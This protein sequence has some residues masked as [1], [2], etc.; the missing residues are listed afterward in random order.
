MLFKLA[1]KNAKKSFKDYLI[2]FLT[3]TISISVF[4]MVNSIYDQ[5]ILLNLQETSKKYMKDMSEGI[6]Y[7]SIFLAVVI[8]FLVVSTNSF[9]IKRRKKELGIYMVLGMEKNKISL[10]LILEILFIAIF[11]LTLGILVGTILSQFMSFLI[12]NMFIVDMTK[13]TFVFSIGSTM[14]TIS[15]FSV[16]F[17]VIM[18]FNM[19][20]ISKVK[21]IDLL[22]ANK[23][24]SKFKIRSNK[25][26]FILFFISIISLI[27]SYYL[28]L[29]SSEVNP[30]DI[31]SIQI[32]TMD[33][34]Y[35]IL[36]MVGTFL[37]FTSFIS[38]AIN[39]LK[40]N[41]RFYYNKIN[42][43]TVRQINSN[44]IN[45]FASLSVICFILFFIIITGSIGFSMK[46]HFS[47]TIEKMPYN[48]SMYSTLHDNDS[49]KEEKNI[50]I[51]TGTK[52]YKITNREEFLNAIDDN[53][54]TV[55]DNNKNIT[56]ITKIKTY[57]LPYL[58]KL[59]NI[60]TSNLHYTQSSLPIISVSDF[61]NILKSLNK[62]PLTLNDNEYILNVVDDDSNFDKIIG[63]N[64]SFLNGD[65]TLS[66]NEKTLPM[67]EVIDENFFSG[68]M[69]TNAFIVPDEIVKNLM[70]YTYIININTKN[71][72]SETALL[73]ELTNKFDSFFRY[74][75]YVSAFGRTELFEQNN[76]IKSI[77]TFIIVYIS[78][79]FTV[80]GLSILAVQQLCEL[81]D[82]KNKYS[83]LKKLGVEKKE[84]NRSILTQVSLQL[85][86]PLSLS[87]IH[88]IVSI[89]GLNKIFI[90]LNIN[91][92]NYLPYILLLILPI[93]FVY[94]IATYISSKTILE[95]N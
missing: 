85:F 55:T 30:V 71:K 27:T 25:K 90:F 75:T 81:Q 22:N 41:K 69:N 17:I 48:I 59:Y 29:T 94:F 20:S 12:A 49:Y 64:L 54:S 46:D 23:Q 88:S 37:F 76:M 77:Y 86:L 13:Y 74:P 2:Y 33:I 60:D 24:A 58:K 91:L 43:F 53:L 92:Y 42:I 72:A 40:K 31:I 18:I 73:K 9:F 62:E 19:I 32:D 67:K 66:F 35:V 83:L 52:V 38:F 70:P 1:S 78:L 84:I 82:S 50:T 7:I 47:K 39:I 10:I 5:S 14:K 63:T 3:L 16:I 68:F 56:S 36:G 34:L 95:K 45:Y 80:I 89:Y 87:L 11:S 79:V 93:Y 65:V 61:N 21:L 51:N 26:I 4:Y 6:Y 28:F 8:G 15:L 44:I 57:H